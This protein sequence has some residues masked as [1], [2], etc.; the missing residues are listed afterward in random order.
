MNALL[1]TILGQVRSHPCRLQNLIAIMSEHGYAPYDFTT[2][3][4]RPYDHAVGLCEIAFAREN[5]MLRAHLGWQSP[6][7]LE[8]AREA[9]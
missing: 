4:R 3:Q 8:L 1:R 2:F 6:E 7:R 9:A 5:G